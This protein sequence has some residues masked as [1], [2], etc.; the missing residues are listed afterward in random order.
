MNKRVSLIVLYIFISSVISACSRIEGTI[1]LPLVYRVDIHQGNAIEQSM[2][3]KLEY[4]MGKEKVIFI[5]GTPLL[6]DPFHSNRWE[7]IYIVERNG[8]V[9]NQR[10][11][12]LFFKGDKL[13]HIEGDITAVARKRNSDEENDTEA[14]SIVIS[15]KNNEGGFL[16][17]LFSGDQDGDKVRNKIQDEDQDLEQDKIQK[18]EQED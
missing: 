17:K 10:R 4:G 15:G 7:Y 16:D 2:L 3:D 11:I 8:E 9:R 6:I 5:M 12:T 13:V 1:K 18:D 14:T